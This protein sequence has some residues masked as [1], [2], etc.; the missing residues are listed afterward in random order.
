MSNSSIYPAPTFF[1]RFHEFY[2]RTNGEESI[3]SEQE[4]NESNWNA[5]VGSSRGALFEK[6]GF[7]SVNIV[8]G[9]IANK[10]GQVSL[11]ETVAYPKNLS[12]PGFI[13]M[14]NMNRGEDRDDMLVLYTDLIFQDGRT[15]S[16]AGI[17]FKES[18]KNAFVDCQS[19]YDESTKR[20]ANPELLGGSGGR[21]GVLAFVRPDDISLV[22]AVISAALTA[23]EQITSDSAGPEHKNILVSDVHR[24]RARLIEWI[25]R[26]NFGVQVALEN[27]VPLEVIEAY[28]FPPVIRY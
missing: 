23:Y 10:S 25:I 16:E 11:L 27:G 18:L 28:A 15:Q 6:A 21:C 24:T 19:I 12:I 14:T 8:K 17:Q 13:L 20:A 7:A 9:I 5:R 1:D 4:W 2:T 3:Q 26:R 22:D